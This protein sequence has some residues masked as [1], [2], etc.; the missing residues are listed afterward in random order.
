MKR[1]EEYAQERS[2]LNK[3]PIWRLQVLLGEL[4]QQRYEQNDIT[5]ENLHR[6]ASSVYIQRTRRAPSLLFHLKN[7][8]GVVG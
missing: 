1:K 7:F 4:Y 6:L 3:M 5:V 2:R 8:V